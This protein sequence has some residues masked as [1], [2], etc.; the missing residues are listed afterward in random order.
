VVRRRWCNGDH[1]ARTR[2]DAPALGAPPVASVTPDEVAALPD[3]LLAYHREFAP[4]FRRQEQQRWARKYTEGQLLPLERKSIEPLADALVGGDVQAMQ[5]FIGLGAWDDDAVLARHQKLV[6]EALDDAVTG[7]PIV[8]GCDFPKQGT[9][10]VGVARQYCGAL[11]KV[12]RRLYVPRTGS[13][14]PMRTG[15]CA[16]APSG[17]PLPDVHRIGVGAG[18]GAARARR[19]AVP[20]GHGR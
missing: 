3:E 19:P 10:S 7:V 20:L 15:A 9:H 2:P 12:D 1:P 18:R 6:A 16:V 17:P 13:R 14:R 4:L 5:Q 11:G 8:D